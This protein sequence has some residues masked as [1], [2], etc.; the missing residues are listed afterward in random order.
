VNIARTRCPADGAGVSRHMRPR[1]WVLSIT[2]AVALGAAC[3][4]AL[5]GPKPGRAEQATTTTSIPRTPDGKPD[6]QGFWDAATLTPLERPREAQGRAS[7][8]PEQAA[9]IERAA[10]QRRELGA[11]QSRPDRAAPPVGG[12]DAAGGVGGYNGFWVDRGSSVTSI[13]GRARTSL[14]VDPPDG[15]VPPLTAEARRRVAARRDL[16]DVFDDVEARPLGERCLMG[17]GSTAGPPALP[18]LYNNIKQI[19]QTPTNVMILNE[20][21]HDARIVRMNARH[22]PSSV[23]K[24]LG[25]SIGRWEGDTLVVETTHFTD[26]TRFRG[27]GEHLTVIERFTRLDAKTLLYQF[28]VDD[29][30]TWTRPW[31]GE[32]TWA[33]SDQPIY[34]YACHE[35]NYSL[36]GILK[37]ARR[38]DAEGSPRQPGTRR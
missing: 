19:V 10:A 14:V 15:R 38:Q 23:R 9:A 34:E 13:G 17:F 26:K 22:L 35:A 36:E 32:Y 37:G 16:A 3:T 4:P 27:S 11:R 21:V 24:W 25:D 8:T 33:W 30:T 7:L 20:M 6:L 12:V 1:S 2:L 31:S 18:V 5:G 29:P 28:T